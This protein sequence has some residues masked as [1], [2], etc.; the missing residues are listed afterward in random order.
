MRGI[1][2][3]VYVDDLKR[4][5]PASVD[6]NTGVLYINLKVW[7]KIKVWEHRFFVLL[8]EYAHVVLNTSDELAVDKL[9]FELY[10][11]YGCS[12]TKSV[13]ALSELLNNNNPDHCWRTYLQ[14]ERAKEFDYKNNGNKEV[15]HGR[16]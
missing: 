2:E 5:T 9:A 10:A 6:R 1:T 12:L 11:K 15:Y 4:N 7:N 16:N 8:H 13:T 3:I 14:L